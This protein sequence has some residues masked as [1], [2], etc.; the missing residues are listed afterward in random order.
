MRPR[1]PRY[2]K[3]AI[4][5][6]RHHPTRA[7]FHAQ[8]L[9][10]TGIVMTNRILALSAIAALSL[11]CAREKPADTASGPASGDKLGE[12]LGMKVPESV[13]Y[14]AELDVYYV[15]NVNGNPSVK[16]N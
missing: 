5:C 12:T 14:D 6:C 9:T 16:D 1:N 11:A 2:R 8:L 3:S 4:P 13:K 7:S 15:S 10:P